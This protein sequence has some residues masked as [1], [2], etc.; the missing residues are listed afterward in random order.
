MAMADWFGISLAVHAE[1]QEV[2]AEQVLAASGSPCPT[3]ANSSSSNPQGGRTVLDEVDELQA[4]LEN[5]ASSVSMLIWGPRS[6]DSPKMLRANSKGSYSSTGGIDS[7]T[8][9]VD[10]K[11]KKAL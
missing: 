6:P 2:A 8:L 7:M 3:P 4:D 1:T 9:G 5:L 10:L 11:E